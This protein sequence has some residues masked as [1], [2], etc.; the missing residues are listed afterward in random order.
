MQQQ[1]Y[2]LL[3]QQQPPLAL[4]SRYAIPATGQL[5]KA[6]LSNY[7]SIQNIMLPHQFELTANEWRI[8]LRVSQWQF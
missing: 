7:K 6:Q 1:H 3:N 2:I 8:K 5:W 4:L